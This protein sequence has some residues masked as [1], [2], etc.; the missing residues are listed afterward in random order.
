MLLDARRLPDGEE[1]VCD[2]CVI[3]AGAAGITLAREF[4]ATAQSLCV[5]ESGDLEIDAETQALYE[6]E[7]I[8]H[9]YDVARTR[10]RYFGGSTN[11]WNGACR[12]LDAIDFSFRAWV[13]E[14]G[15]PIA[16]SDLHPYYARAQ[17]VCSLGPYRYDL[18]Y[19][20]ER[21]AL[22]A[23]LSGDWES[24]LWQLSRGLRFGEKYR[25]EMR[26]AGNLRVLLNAN[27]VDIAL[28]GDGQRVRHVVVATLA[29]RKFTVTA[30]DY[31]LA[32]GGI[33]NARLLLASDDVA[34]RGIG[35]LHDL[36]G[37]F[38]MDH[39]NVIAGV[40]VLSRTPSGGNVG[41]AAV[42]GVELLEGFRLGSD[43]QRR[44]EVTNF[45]FFPVTPIDPI[46]S[47]QLQGTPWQAVQDLASTLNGAASRGARGAALLQA[48][49][50]QAPNRDSRVVLADTVDR[51][52]LR[53]VRLDWRLGALETKALDA[54]L[55]SLA[56]EVGRSGIG[57]IHL[58]PPVRDLGRH[59]LGGFAWG[60]NH[61]IGTTRMNP[62]PRQC[63][64]DADCRVHGIGNLYV[65]GSSVFPTSGLSN[66]TLTI[67]ALALRLADFLKT[68][69]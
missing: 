58:A 30:R 2:I 49:F 15:W 5:I 18:A 7:S 57:R 55:V 21:G 44:Q 63:V 45:S 24:A 13:P 22:A 16:P 52:G 6:G 69:P 8:G 4:A 25:D 64:V 60:A 27:L 33:E 53:R 50:E 20:R 41:S 47:S 9:R 11:H 10:L 54:G 23:A 65:A 39:P 56:R 26:R 1:L 61:H 62:D 3:G 59:G 31:V 32:C 46:Q 14:S 19:W 29:G 42:D 35:N 51:L 34:R 40:L 48:Y 43:A 28:T 66:P 37:R 36:V 38:F 17:E 67:V 68:K 12:P